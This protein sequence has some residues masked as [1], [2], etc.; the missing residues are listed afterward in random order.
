[1]TG[2]YTEMADQAGQQASG[3][4]GAGDDNQ[5]SQATTAAKMAAEWDLWH[6]PGGDAYVTVPVGEHDETILF[7]DW[8]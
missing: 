4:S 5:E 3:S 1:M 8:V 7:R 2:S 6:T